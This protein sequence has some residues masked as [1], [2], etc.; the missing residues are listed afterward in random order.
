M[1]RVGLL[2]A[3]DAKVTP[4]QHAR[5]SVA[6][7][8]DMSMKFSGASGLFG[9][10][11][12]FAYCQADAVPRIRLQDPPESRDED[13]NRS[14]VLRRLHR[15]SIVASRVEMAALVAPEAR[16]SSHWTG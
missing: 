4:S 5:R 16:Y 7:Q 15:G 11:S 9:L 6:G 12:L 8:S 10:V 3:G 2:T 1:T 14:R 13:L